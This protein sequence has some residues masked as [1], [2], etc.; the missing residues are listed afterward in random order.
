MFGSQGWKDLIED[1][2]NILDKT[3]DI[4]PIFNGEQLQY[5]KGELSILKWIL[6][7]ED[8]SRTAYDQLLAED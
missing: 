3:N 2:Q 4:E 1:V 7:L 6:A 5:K 8:M